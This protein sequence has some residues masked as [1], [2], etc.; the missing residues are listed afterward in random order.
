MRRPLLLLLGLL[1]LP[2]CPKPGLTPETRLPPPDP[3]V[4]DLVLAAGDR[5]TL[6]LVLR[7]DRWPESRDTLKTLV[8]FLP[9]P[10][11]TLENIF[12]AED[13]WTAFSL[14]A[15][16][17]EGRRM[18]LPSRLPGWDIS[19]PV[20]AALFEPQTS[21]ATLAARALI[22]E[23][24][25]KS[26]PGLRHR[27]LVPSTD[28]ALTLEGLT[29]LLTSLGTS[30]RRDVLPGGG[31]IFP[32]PEGFVAF[33]PGDRHVRVEILTGEIHHWEKP[34]KDVL[35][36]WMA[37]AEKPPESAQLPMTPALHALLCGDDLLAAYI[38]PWQLRDLMSQYGSMKIIEALAYV[39]PAQRATL[40]AVGLAE[41]AVGSLIMS[42]IGAEFDDITVG[43]SAAGPL[44]LKYTESLTELGRKVYSAGLKE[45]GRPFTLKMKNVLARATLPV[46]IGSL[47]DAAE[48]IEALS[49]AEDASEA[50]QSF[51]ECGFGCSLHA[52]LRNPMGLLKTLRKF[53]Q[54]EMV[55]HLPE[56]M[57]FVLVD[58][59]PLN[60]DRHFRA[61]LAARMPKGFDT[62]WLRD[63]LIMLEKDGKISTHLEMRAQM[64]HD[65]V[66][67]GFNI[68]PL[69]V[70]DI[71]AQPPEKNLLAVFELD[72]GSLA[73]AFARL[74]PHL[75]AVFDRYTGMRGRT[76]ISGRGLFSE[77]VVGIA[78]QPEPAWTDP[79]NYAG[80]SWPSP[81]LKEAQSKGGRCLAAVTLNMIKAFKALSYADPAYRT[82]ILK[83]A[84]DMTA[85]EHLQC[86]KEFEGTREEAERIHE[87]MILYIDEQLK[88]E[89]KHE[90]RLAHLKKACAEG[91]ATAC[92]REKEVAKESAVEL[93]QLDIPCGT[94]PYGVRAAPVPSTGEFSPVGTCAIAP[95]KNVTFDKL[96]R[97]FAALSRENCD[98][99]EILLK[100]RQGLTRS[101]PAKLDSPDEVKIPLAVHL[102]NNAVQLKGP[103]GTIDIKEKNGSLDIEKLKDTIERTREAFPDVVFY[104]LA[105]AETRWENVAAV[106]VAVS[107]RED[108]PHRLVFGQA[109]PM[110][111]IPKTPKITPGS[112]AVMGSLS[113]TAIRQAVKKHYTGF[114]YCYEKMLVKNPSLEGK[115]VLKFV[116]SADGTVSDA[117]VAETTIDSPKLKDCMLRVARR[118]VFPQPK[119]G[120][121]VVVKYPF[122]FKAVK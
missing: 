112:A 117:S 60:P 56:S 24:L 98:H 59:D 32:L 22:P 66:L 55:R 13:P 74:S 82:Q 72:T 29:T 20:V 68:N 122:L 109:P 28:P 41:V 4:S 100:D 40:L 120:G 18:A 15:E 7:P 44:R 79:V 111:E 88:R 12:A 57:E 78:G 75:A 36:D 96:A 106:L 8:R 89:F 51:R 17:A 45:A 50:S 95:D 90:E 47:L 6:T 121:I 25:Q 30:F 101:V 26:V 70:L 16:A 103:G 2:G 104:L 119:G 77:L 86:A 108:Q 94:D 85:K 118:M 48:I 42:P 87:L 71:E 73:N 9:I 69:E 58:L 84:M 33:V 38:R 113:M 102:S 114:K 27:I 3:A 34:K 107:C 80:L 110:P 37:L 65:A 63:A 64:D 76:V 19:R 52:V 81:G 91:V 67:M 43:L 49:R 93:A 115:V 46:N 5:A 11:R 54:Y 99:L 31:V 92:H 10:P 23:P 61:V 83:K 105:S 62:G 21:D 116:I 53:A 97:V 35:A 39:D 1:C 14:A